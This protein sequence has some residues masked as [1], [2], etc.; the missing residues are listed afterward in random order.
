MPVDATQYLLP[1]GCGLDAAVARLA[2]RF[3]VESGPVEAWDR[4]FY[5]TFDGRLRAAGLAVF[6]ER[7]RLVAAAGPAFAERAAGPIPPG[8]RIFASELAGGALRDLLAPIAEVRALV[9]IARVRGRARGLR[10]RNRD[11]KT[12]VRLV[13]YAAAGVGGD[14]GE[15]GLRSRVL[16]VGVRGYDRALGRVRRELE[17]AGDLEASDVPVHDEAVR[18]AGGTPGGVSSKLDL[19]LAAEEPA[20][21][22]AAIALGEMLRTIEST[23]PGTVADVDTE[24]LHDLRVAVRRTRSVQ[25]QLA[26]VFPVGRLRWFRGEFRW[27]GQ[28]TGP[29]RDLDVLL[30]DLARMR[31]EL[32]P[33][34]AAAL[35][36]LAVLLRA[37]RAVAWGQM[38]AAL[39]SD[40]A[41][42][43]LGEWRAFLEE[44]REAPGDGERPLG[45]VVGDRI[46]A[47][48]GQMRRAGRAIDERTPAEQLH[49]LRKQGKE[50]RYLL[51]IFAG[52]YPASA[53]RPTVKTLKALQETLGQFQDREVQAGMLRELGEE[54]ARVAGGPAALLALGAVLERVEAESVAARAEFGERFAVYA[55][56]DQRA[57]VRRAFR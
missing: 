35:E 18:A 36:P 12:V 6:A 2:E 3:D 8:E 27:L 16:V 5:D 41:G 24:F 52:L 9:P 49:D 34:R 44:L 50:L 26:A 37:R 14:G 51:E 39:E 30:L 15:V 55:A 42:T 32:P 7:G 4:R 23:L 22:G 48:Y 31:A 33:G 17:A 43:V 11:E 19:R 20:T 13:V 45:E 29:T 47:V 46:R 54:L 10:V 40:R 57:V 53:V 28:V 25:R 1:E 21:A 38:V 56:A